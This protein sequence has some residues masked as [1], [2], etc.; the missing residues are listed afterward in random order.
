MVTWHDK[1]DWPHF[2]PEGYVII[3]LPEAPL[4]VDKFE[5]EESWITNSR[6]HETFSEYCTRRLS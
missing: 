1:P 2:V 6:S 4:P 5:Q 3:G